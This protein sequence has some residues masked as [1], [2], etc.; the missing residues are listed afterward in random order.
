MQDQSVTAAK[1]VQQ[2]N[3]FLLRNK[4]YLYQPTTDRQ[5]IHHTILQNATFVVPNRHQYKISI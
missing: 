2:T 4:Q 5:Q 3:V 1:E